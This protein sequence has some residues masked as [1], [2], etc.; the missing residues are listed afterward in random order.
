MMKRFFGSL[1]RISYS[2]YIAITTVNQLAL[3]DC[4]DK[5]KQ[6]ARKD[7]QGDIKEK[8]YIIIIARK[9]ISLLSC[10]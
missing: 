3:G 4:E 9:V 10:R 2:F 6:H 8:L 7:V 5:D 1:C